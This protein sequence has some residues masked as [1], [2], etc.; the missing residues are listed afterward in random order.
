MRKVCA[1]EIWDPDK[2]CPRCI[3]RSDLY[4]SQDKA[5]AAFCNPDTYEVFTAL[6]DLWRETECGLFIFEGD[7]DEIDDFALG[8]ENGD[9]QIVQ[10]VN[11]L[12]EWISGKKPTFPDTDGQMITYEQVGIDYCVTSF[13]LHDDDKEDDE[14]RSVE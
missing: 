7:Y 12:R 5:I 3:Y 4:T 11:L 14:N 2:Y 8:Y 1:I 10:Q 9:A 13:T 6:Y